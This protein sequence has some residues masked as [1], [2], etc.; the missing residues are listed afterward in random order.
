MRGMALIGIVLIVGGIVALAVQ[1]FSYTTKEKVLDV[2]P[3]HATADQEHTVYIAPAASI[4]AIL[5]GGALVFVSRR[6][7]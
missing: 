1:S 3:I 5:A 6:R 7:A 2:G 4:V